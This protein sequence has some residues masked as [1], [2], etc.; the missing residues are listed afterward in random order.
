MGVIVANWLI[1]KVLGVARYNYRVMRVNIVI[2]DVLW[3]GVSSYC[4]QAGK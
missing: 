1:G 4:S 3:E 2:G